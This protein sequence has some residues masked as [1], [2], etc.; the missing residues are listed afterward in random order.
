MFSILLETLFLEV[1][2]RFSDWSE[3]ISLPSKTSE[4]GLSWLI[5]CLRDFFPG[6]EY[7]RRHRA[8][9]TSIFLPVQL[10]NS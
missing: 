3:I 2:D 4:G 7:L 9:W 6:L 10:K 1:G 8:K 5:K